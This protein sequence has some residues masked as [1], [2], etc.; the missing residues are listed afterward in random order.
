MN[1]QPVLKP[2]LIRLPKRLVATMDHLLIDKQLTTSAPQFKSRT[3]LI[4][5]LVEAYVNRVPNNEKPE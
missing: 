4:A 3:S 5:W 2:L 1:D